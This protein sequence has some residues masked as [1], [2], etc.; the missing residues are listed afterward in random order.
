MTMLRL[1]LCVVCLVGTTLTGAERYTLAHTAKIVNVFNPRFSPDG[2]RIVIGVSR[3]NLQE[4]RFDNELVQVDVA[5]KAQRILT[6]RQANQHQWSL[7]G[8]QLAFLAPVDGK[9]QLWVL[10]IDG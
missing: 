3:V 1:A 6:R 2:K 8:T 7:D 10:P 5:T 4:N 9:A